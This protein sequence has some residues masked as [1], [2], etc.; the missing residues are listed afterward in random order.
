MIRLPQHKDG[1]PFFAWSTTLV[2]LLGVLSAWAD[3]ISGC[4]INASGLLLVSFWLLRFG[5][6]GGVHWLI[7]PLLMLSAYGLVQIALHWTVSP[8]ETWNAICTWLSRAAFLYLAFATLKSAKLRTSVLS[9]ALGFGTLFAI[10]GMIQWSTSNGKV[11]WLIPTAYNDEVFGT[12]P[13]R[14]HYAVF[15]ELIL[16]IAL[17]RALMS[18]IRWPYSLAAG[19][20]YASVVESGSRGGT[21]IVSL[22]ALIIMAI[23]LYRRAN[24]Y[25]WVL[26]A[27]ALMTICSLAS[28]WQYVWF[29]FH[30]T[31][32]F[33]FRREMALASIQMIQTRP[34][35]GFG[36]GTWPMVYP[37]FALFDPPG[38]YMNHAHND[39][40][41]LIAEGGLLVAMTILTISCGSVLLSRS[42]LWAIGIPAA[43]LHALVDFPLQKPAIAT[44]IFFLLGAAAAAAQSRNL[45]N[46]GHTIREEG[47]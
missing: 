17:T 33:A 32:L 18:D 26:S 27:A 21:A 3:P 9:L 5:F 36:L 13:N 16:P 22:E 7:I 44:L 38:F 35:R 11:L 19:V 1:A 37:A 2:V 39:W 47:N 31:N 43:L 20:I 24:E 23:A 46:V 14:D 10:I 28:G 29:R 34:L 4:L 42:S 41:E 40:L 6:T 30:S 25:R 12:F 45:N 8:F 15:A